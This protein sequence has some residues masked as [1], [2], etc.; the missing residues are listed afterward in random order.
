MA[1]KSLVYT[2][3]FTQYLVTGTVLNDAG[4][5][6]PEAAPVRLFHKKLHAAAQVNFKPLICQLLHPS[7][8]S[9]MEDTGGRSNT[10]ESAVIQSPYLNHLTQTLQFHFPQFEPLNESTYIANRFPW[11]VNMFFPNFYVI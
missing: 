1:V 10:P 7:E 6:K 4:K 5:F 11:F 2:A 3:R 9:H 8:R